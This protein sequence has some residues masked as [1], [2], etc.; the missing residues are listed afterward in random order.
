MDIMIIT[1][2]NDFCE[3]TFAFETCE[4]GEIITHEG[5]I[6]FEPIDA[7]IDLTPVSSNGNQHFWLL[8]LFLTL[9]LALLAIAHL[10]QTRESRA[11]QT[12][13]GKTVVKNTPV[14]E[15]QILNAVKESARSPV[16]SD[17]VFDRIMA[18]IDNSD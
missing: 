14:S 2:D 16:P 6:G 10:L 12:N 4:D 8:P 17:D 7:R 5:I 3:E 9:L 15:R 11:M 1:D 18:K 13:T